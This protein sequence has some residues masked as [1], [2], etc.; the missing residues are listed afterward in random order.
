MAISQI[1]LMLNN[2]LLC[3]I[4]TKIGMTPIELTHKSRCIQNMTRKFD[5]RKETDASKCFNKSLYQVAKR[6]W[7]LSKDNHKTLWMN[8][9]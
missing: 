7:Y 9:S 6:Q 5:E 8:N 4:A 2:L 3:K 1:I